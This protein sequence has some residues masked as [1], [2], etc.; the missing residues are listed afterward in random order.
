MLLAIDIG[1]SS[2]KFGLFGPGGLIA[3][4][5]TNYDRGSGSPGLPRGIMKA[6]VRPEHAII[7]SVVPG[8]EAEYA[9]LLQK[10]FGIESKTAGHSLDFGLT[11]RYRPPED[12]GI[13]RILAAAAAREMAGLPSIVCDF[14]TATTIDAVDAE[15]TFLGGT[16]S[17]GIGLL[18]E[19][20]HGKTAK[21]PMVV[22]GEPPGV[23]GD[24]T[25]NSIRSGIYYGYTGLVDGLIARIMKELGED[26]N[27]IA[28]G[29]NAGLIAP[30]SRFIS[31][32]E[33]N[34][35]LEG[36]ALVHR[37]NFGTRE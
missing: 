14:G 25:A 28:T 35:V 4:A 22:I 34:L 27:V 6:S 3:A 21:L 1:N 31:T 18:A 19:T 26:A 37:R 7:S 24:S 16:I 36:L 10:E 32:I 33:P 29:G 11:I 13:D 9:G 15:G 17:P 12:C 2:T 5:R 20:L 23:I 8:Y 30:A